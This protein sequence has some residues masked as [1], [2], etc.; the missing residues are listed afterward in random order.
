MRLLHAVT[1]DITEIPDESLV[2]MIAAIVPY[3]DYI[4]LRE[5]SRSSKSLGL[6][7]ERL[8][9]KEIPIEKL[10]IN[11]R[12]DIAAAF[13]I[14]RTHLTEKS[15]SLARLQDAFPQ[16]KFGRSFHS[17]H[18]IERELAHYDYGYLGHIF[19]TSEKHY[20]ALGRELLMEAYQVSHRKTEI[21]NAGK[22]IAIGGI[23]VDTLPKICPYIDGAAVMSALFPITNHHFDI[24]RGRARAQ[25]LRNILADQST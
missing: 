4:Q 15:L 12:A 9:E 10:I 8:L 7:I 1:R 6:L 20:P 13:D 14:P 3:I 24:E 19:R 23:N 25:A 11:D 17:L 2:A 18:A 16:M 5:K 22:L 21:K